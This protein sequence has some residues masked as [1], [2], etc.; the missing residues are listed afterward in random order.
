MSVILPLKDK[1]L[2]YYLQAHNDL[3]FLVTIMSELSKN[4]VACYVK[5][6]S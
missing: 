1:A 5:S 2:D 3:K 4:L 6:S